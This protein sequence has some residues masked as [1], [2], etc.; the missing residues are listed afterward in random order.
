MTNTPDH[1]RGLDEV[2]VVSNLTRPMNKTTQSVA[3]DSLGRSIGK[4]QSQGNPVMSSTEA[5]SIHFTQPDGMYATSRLK[6]LV[7]SNQ[8]QFNRRDFDTE[9]TPNQQNSVGH[10]GVESPS[11]FK[12]GMY[13]KALVVSP[14]NRMQKAQTPNDFGRPRAASMERKLNRRFQMPGPGFQEYG[15]IYRQRARFGSADFNANQNIQPIKAARQSRGGASR[16]NNIDRLY[17]AS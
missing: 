7:C 8:T 12:L 17:V 13:K 10:V 14:P 4:P 3:H 2:R 6:H 9:L 5:D 15:A 11:R 16:T 1:T